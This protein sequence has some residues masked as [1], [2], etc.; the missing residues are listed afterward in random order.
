[1]KITVM[2][3][4][5]ISGLVLGTVQLGMPYGIAN[6]SGMPDVKTGLE[7]IQEAINGGVNTL[8]T[9]SAYG[10]SEKIIGLYNKSK[11][12]S[13]RPLVVT[14]VSGIKPGMKDKEIFDY[15]VRSVERS[16]SLLCLD[17]IPIVLLHSFVEWKNGG[18]AAV[19][20]LEYLKDRGY[21]KLAGISLYGSDDT[22]RVLEEPVFD[23][24]QVPV[25]IFDLR[26][27]R[28]GALER[29]RQKGMIV[30]VR[31]IY[32][33]G[34]LFLEPEELSGKLTQAKPYIEK[35]RAL[36]SK[37]QRS[38]AETALAYV[39]DQEA[40]TGLVLGCETIEQVRKNIELYHTPPLSKEMTEEIMD[41][42]QSVPDEVTDPRT[43]GK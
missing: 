6:I 21:I 33:Q 11:K 32:L 4:L 25:N 31:S 17:T 27:V 42:F 13:E 38:I 12:D 29:L 16:C 40:V 14:K 18:K 9:A 22:D 41:C 8:D 28:S 36:C 1:M 39:R 34:L 7:I 26:L 24:V 23:A 43:W 3:D 5:A 19:E 2:K 37:E 35:L 30:F 20:A 10:E 15:T